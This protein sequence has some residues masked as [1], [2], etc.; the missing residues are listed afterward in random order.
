[1]LSTRSFAT[2]PGARKLSFSSPETPLPIPRLPN[3]LSGSELLVKHEELSMIF[4]VQALSM[5]L[6]MYLFIYP[7]IY[8]VIY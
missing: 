6:S 3:L 1:M 4:T 5:Y 2:M 7:S 8:L